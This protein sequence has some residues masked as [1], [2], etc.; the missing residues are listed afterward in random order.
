MEQLFCAVDV[1]TTTVAASIINEYGIVLARDGFLNPQK[2]FGSDVISRITNSSRGNHLSEMRR[3]LLQELE[4]CL[5]SLIDRSLPENERMQ[6]DD[7][8]RIAAY[9]GKMCISANTVMASIVL[10]KDISKMGC[11]P[12]PMPFQENET[13]KLFGVPTIVLAGAAAFLGG[14]SLAGADFLNLL[15]GDIL[16]DLGT[17]GEII[18]RNNG[19]YH[20]ATAAC[21]PAFENCTR[22]RKINGSTSLSAIS[23]LIKRGKIRR[24][25]VLQEAFIENGLDTVMNGVSFHLTS[26]ILRDIQLAVSAIYSTLSLLMEEAELAVEDVRNLYISGGFG[27]YMNLSDGAGLG[28]FPYRLLPKTK[29]TGNTS[30]EGACKIL[31]KCDSI[32]TFDRLRKSIVLH[33]F[34]GNDRYQELFVQNLALCKR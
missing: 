32:T 3:L 15:D 6:T 18:L 12:F 16:M 7:E 30:L 13:I 25:G 26:D 28:L 29:I 14:D 34:G 21:G 22:S 11:A 17:N 1:G 2:R 9:I 8:N 10:G 5:L 23:Y 19:V 4:E 20:G 31:T 33:Q 27:F 24:D